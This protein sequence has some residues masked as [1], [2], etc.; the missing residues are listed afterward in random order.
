MRSGAG[1]VVAAQDRVGG[2]IDV[3]LGRRPVRHRDAHRLL[4]L[5][6][7]AAGPARAFG[8]H[9]RRSRRACVVGVVVP[10]N[11]TSTWFSTTSLRMRDAGLARQ[12]IGHAPRQRAV[13]AHDVGDAVAAE[14][15]EQ[16][17]ERHA[18]ATGATTPA[19]SPCRRALRRRRAG[20]TTPSGPSP[21]DAAPASATIA[22]PESYGTLSHLCA[23][24][25]HE[26]A[27]A[28]CRR[29][30][31]AAPEPRPPTGRTRRR[32]AP[33]RRARAR[34]RR[35][36]PIGSLAPVLTLPACAQTIVG[37]SHRRRARPRAHRRACG[38]D[39][40]PERARSRRCRSR[41]SAARRPPRCALRRRRSRGSR[42]APLQP[43][44]L[45]VPAGAAQ[46]FVTRRRQAGEVRHV[47][48][49]DEADAGAAR[50]VEQL[51]E[52]ADDD[53]FDHG[54]RPATCT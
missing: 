25:A 5:P 47:A 52:P 18:R 41:G 16:R 19:P 7:R 50:Q 48:A 32:R 42:G 8:L 31:R 6:Q 35:S 21:P 17:V 36:R 24:V 44:R 39:R 30:A 20:G 45:D 28:R 2:L 15:P 38:P 4:A 22:R 3:G 33:T 40:R 12:A 43:L 10:S 29:P 37:P 54:R 14:R 13:A 1:L 9:P 49:G 53:V 46:H 51:E 27:R 11:C 23:S 34:C 26:S